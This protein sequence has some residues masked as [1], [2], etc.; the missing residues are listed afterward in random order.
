MI[1]LAN[2]SAFRTVAGRYGFKE[3]DFTV[4]KD[5]DARLPSQEYPKSG[6]VTVVLRTTGVQRT[7]GFGAGKDWLPEFEADLKKGVF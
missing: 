6:S 3:E 2:R 7:Y 5:L 4:R 1:E